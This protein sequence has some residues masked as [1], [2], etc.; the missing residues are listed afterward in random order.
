MHYIDFAPP[1]TGLDN[2]F[3]TIRMGLFYSKRLTVGE[4][5]AIVDSKAKKIVGHATVTGVV[6]GPLGE[7]LVE[8]AETNHTQIGLDPMTAPERLFQVV[9]KLYGPHIAIRTRSA[10]VVQLRRL[11]GSEQIPST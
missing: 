5:V 6:A 10:T 7:L 3:N 1:L 8:Y 9:T 11:H 2:E 4:T